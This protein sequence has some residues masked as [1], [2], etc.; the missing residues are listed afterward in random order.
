MFGKSLKCC[1]INCYTYFTA[2]ILVF[3]PPA[4]V[5]PNAQSGP[6]GAA[7]VVKRTGGKIAEDH[8]IGY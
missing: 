5:G 8:G 3:S 6:A 4:S 2:G 7:R 1:V